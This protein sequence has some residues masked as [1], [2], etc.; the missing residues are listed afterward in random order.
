MFCL[1]SRFEGFGLSAIEAML[2][3]RVLIVSEVA[4]VAPHVKASGCGVVV[5][6]E[7][8]AVRDGLRELLAKRDEWKA[9]GLAGRRHALKHLRWP[10]IAAAALRDYRNLMQ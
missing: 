3:G 4:G 9:M 6:P 8:S 10:T 2:A 1:P 7:R 5:A